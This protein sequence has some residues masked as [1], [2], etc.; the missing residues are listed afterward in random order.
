MIQLLPNNTD[1][2]RQVHGVYL[3][4]AAG[5]MLDLATRAGGSGIRYFARTLVG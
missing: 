1:L 4:G 2:K 5:L 3:P